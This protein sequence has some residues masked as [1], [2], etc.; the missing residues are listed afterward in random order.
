MGWYVYIAGAL[1]ISQLLFST[2]TLKNYFFALA[3]YD[4]KHKR[5]APRVAL[6]IPCK[7]LDENFEQNIASFYRQDYENYLLW[8]V[9]EDKADPAYEQL[10][11]IKGQ[12]GLEHKGRRRSGAYC[13]GWAG[14]QPENP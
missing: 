11:R 5:Y 3:K 12:I 14:M 4:K 13:R 1:I 10:R 9:V 8:F 6:I 7:N 2:L